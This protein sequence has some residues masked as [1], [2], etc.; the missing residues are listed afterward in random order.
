MISEMN[1]YFVSTLTAVNFI[2]K[3]NA[4]MLSIHPSKFFF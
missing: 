4:S 3:L 1:Y 2:E